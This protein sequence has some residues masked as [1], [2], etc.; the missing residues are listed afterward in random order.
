[1]TGKNNY[2]GISEKF[3]GI[4]SEFS[5]FLFKN[6]SR[7]KCIQE[8]FSV[9]VNINLA[10]TMTT[11]LLFRDLCALDISL[12]ICEALKMVTSC[13]ATRKSWKLNFHKAWL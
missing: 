7:E 9:P 6:F 1:M 10:E 11:P 2:K 5:T 3:Y 4:F 8:I 13:C 12:K